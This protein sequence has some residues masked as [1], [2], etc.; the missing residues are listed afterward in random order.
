MPPTFVIANT[1]RT[2]GKSLKNNLKMEDSLYNEVT[3]LC[4]EKKWREIGDMFHEHPDRNKLLWVFPSEENFRFLA[5]CVKELGCEKVLSI[6][7]GS[8][9]LEWMFTEATGESVNSVSSR[10]VGRYR[11]SRYFLS[12]RSLAG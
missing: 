7:C 1:E 6:G 9:L 4:K 10:E 2:G 12:S 3:A 5:E 8:G 11:Q